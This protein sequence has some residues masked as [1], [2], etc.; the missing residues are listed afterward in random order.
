MAEEA[1][2]DLL[3]DQRSQ[4]IIIT[5]ESGAGK[6][7]ATKILMGYLANCRDDFKQA[8]S[9]LFGQ[10]A[11]GQQADESLEQQILDANP[12][13]EAFGNAK[14]V[15]NDNSSRFGKFIRINFG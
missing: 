1:F 12:L 8:G 7:E 6:T 15:K 2:Q 14:T 5:G 10:D 3:A 9:S 4:A 13:L 11:V